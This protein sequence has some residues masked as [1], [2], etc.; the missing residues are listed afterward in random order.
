[1]TMDKSLSKSY[2]I[3]V[4]ISAFILFLPSVISPSVAQD[5][6]ATPS[7]TPSELPTTAVPSPTDTDMPPVIPTATEIPITPTSPAELPSQTPTIM[8][9]PSISPEATELPGLPPEVTELPSLTPTLPPSLTAVPTDR[10]T[11]TPV[12][13]DPA[14]M[15]V[16][17]DNFDSGDTSH[18]ILGSGWS[19]A[20]TEAGNVL[21]VVNS[22]EPTYLNEAVDAN[23]VL[24][25]DFLPGR[26]TVEIGIRQNAEQGYTFH[27][28]PD[29]FMRLAKA[30]ISVQTTSLDSF[31]LSRWHTLRISALGSV[32]RVFVDGV[33]YLDYADDTPPQAGR[34]FI[35]GTLSDAAQPVTEPRL[36]VDNIGLWIP[37]S[38]A[39]PPTATPEVIPTI[40]PM[41]TA[42]DVPETMPN[43]PPLTLLLTDG[44][45]AGEVSYWELGTGWSL[46][47]FVNGPALQV[48]NSA[49]PIVFMYDNLFNV[50]AQ[51]Q[52]WLNTNA[53][54]LNVRQSSVGSYRAVL[55]ADGT[56]NLFR[57]GN[58]LA[59]AQVESFAGDSGHL[60]RLSAMDNVIRIAVDGYEII[61]VE[62]AAPLPPGGIT[63]ASD[64]INSE[65]LL[66]DDFSLWMP[67]GNLLP[68]PTLSPSATPLPT[69]TPTATP[70]KPLPASQPP[71]ESSE[72]SPLAV[73]NDNFAN[74]ALIHE[75]IYT[76][77]G[78]TDTA[79]NETGEPTPSCAIAGIGKTIWYS[80]T[81]PLTAEYRFSTLGSSFD[82]I[83]A[84][85][86]GDSI[87][88][89]TLLACNDD[90]GGGRTEA[91]LPLILQQGQ[92]IH[93]QLGGWGG[94][95]G[96][97]LFEVRANVSLP[98]VPVLSSP[99]N[100]TMTNKLLPVF[101]WSAANNAFTYQI[102]IDNNSNFS[103]PEQENIVTATNYAADTLGDGLYYWRVRSLNVNRQYGSWSATWRFTMDTVP[104]LPPVLVVPVDKG[105][106]NDTTPT[107]TWRSSAT[108]TLYRLQITD[109]SGDF[110]SPI[111][112]ITSTA[113]AFTP[114]TPLDYGY[115]YV[116]R[117]SARDAAG[118]WGNWS[119]N[120]SFDITIMRSPLNGSSTADK[121]PAFAWL[122]MPGAVRYEI[123]ISPY[124]N[125]S[126][127]I[128]SWITNTALSY[129]IPANQSLPYGVYY[130]HVKVDMGSGS[131]E[132]APLVWS[133]TITPPPPGSVTLVA[134][135]NN[136]VFG[137]IVPL[138]WSRA[139]GGYEY[140]LQISRNSTFTDLYIDRLMGADSSL[141]TVNINLFIEGE[142]R[143]YWRVR[144]VNR[145]RFI[146]YF[147][148]GTW[149]RPRSFTVD[150]TAP[151]VPGLTA[152]ADTATTTS[153]TP[154]FSWAAS[155]GANRY[156][157][158]LGTTNPPTT[159]YSVGTARSYRHPAP[160][161]L[162]T[163]YWRVRAMDAAGN[164]SVWSATRSLV[165]ASPA[166]DTPRLNRYPGGTFTL[167]WARV[168]WAT[169]YEIQVD[170]NSRFTS[171]EYSS[172][173]LN[174]NSLEHTI[175]TPLADGIWYWRIRAYNSSGRPGRWSTTG[176]FILEF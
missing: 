150:T 148:P 17:R 167:T 69:L 145:D 6:A 129:T 22:D 173:L 38:D 161:L 12:V 117:M 106:T 15:L 1:M 30:G 26:G 40:L 90:Y 31:D 89:L 28:E 3:L 51:A 74:A 20:E 149:S 58:L 60:L 84:A 176:S 49:Q 134:P 133:V 101:T 85:Y 103:S 113:R 63:I 127:I 68:E 66:V 171:P 35:R 37:V 116:W 67:A 112:D 13:P 128:S 50:A 174:V 7:P 130:W 157:I 172:G 48:V 146:G 141:P 59:S 11:E 140:E 165:V 151:P 144:G 27:I 155:A 138:S 62:D 80:F 72:L 105:G 78:S 104:P 19:L 152:P 166:N 164:I 73:S 8:V 81:A 137:S 114:T 108:A 139:V 169:G 87:T 18:W 131:F 56:V 92:T 95:S 24:E 25:V 61:V 126:L 147:V 175:T 4:L 32:I 88:Q 43:E 14:L 75:L 118:N 41:A 2:R 121:T 16:F 93:I 107:L 125:M 154:T 54:S 142:S 124:S 135:A 46:T 160:L 42:T 9:L 44:F 53:A 71:E 115:R 170:D 91:Y 97:Y 39:V 159:T 153:R 98:A 111:V 10:P 143:Y 120:R 79:S 52:F 109:D 102:Q 45:D 5:S 132:P 57:A 158:Q 36:S 168:S 47:S 76:D 70:I 77:T 83:L 86:S 33:A 34:I 123:E 162:G 96:L 110:T 29:G 82:T 156:E 136:A 100:G 21:Q 119:E 23:I 64:G 122:R 163:Y 99:T 94:W 65:M 55:S